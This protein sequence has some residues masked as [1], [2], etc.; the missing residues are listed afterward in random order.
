QRLVRTGLVDPGTDRL[1]HPHAGAARPA[2][3]RRLAV[4]RHLGQ[5]QAGYAAEDLP[6]R[7]EDPVVPPEVAR[8]VIGDRGV[9]LVY[10]RQPALADEP[11]QQLRV[12][13]DLVDAAQLWVLVAQ[14]VEA[15]RAGDH[16]LPCPGVVERL[17]VL[18][19]QLLEQ[20]L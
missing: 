14:R 9:H 18:R 16:D 5:P 11:G 12:V 20:Q 1:L 2:A 8:V 7:A 10:R 15:V 13:Y 6:R 3:E 17:D 19:G 4:A